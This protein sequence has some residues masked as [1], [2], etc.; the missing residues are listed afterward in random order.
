MQKNEVRVTIKQHIKCQIE[1]DYPMAK[2][3]FR[4]KKIAK[5]G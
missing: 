2:N 3:M 4:R 1:I 5:R